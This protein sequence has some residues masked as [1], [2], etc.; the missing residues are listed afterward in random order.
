[1]NYSNDIVVWLGLFMNGIPYLLFLREEHRRKS[2]SNNEVRLSAYQ[3]CILCFS[4]WWLIAVIWVSPWIFYR[5]AGNDLPT[6]VFY[7]F[8]TGSAI[9]ILIILCHLAPDDVFRDRRAKK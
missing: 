4:S 3:G 7:G 2:D 8:L 5:L 1:M 9:A 6:S